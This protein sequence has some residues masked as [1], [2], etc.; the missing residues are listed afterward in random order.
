[1]HAFTVWT[2]A[3]SILGLAHWNTTSGM[4]IRFFD[5]SASVWK[6]VVPVVHS[7]LASSDSGYGKDGVVMK[8][9]ARRWKLVLATNW[10]LFIGDRQLETLLSKE[11]LRRSAR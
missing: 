11:R 4:S 8:T 10:Q 3:L 5:A 2:R 6:P 9:L 1:M 7:G